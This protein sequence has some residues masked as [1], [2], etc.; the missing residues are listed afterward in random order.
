M[1]RLLV[2]GMSGTGK[3]SVLA[4]LAR[5]GVRVVDTDDEGW[6]DED[7]FDA[8]VL[9]SAP[10]GVL[11]HRLATR[12]TNGYGRSADERARV[13]ADLAEV[14][15]LLRRGAAAEVRTDRPLDE[16]VAAVLAVV[17]RVC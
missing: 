1:P 13:L 9:L 6:T 4:E 17:A 10:V 15:P 2:T 11:L 16:V 12:T 7:R 8:V 5:R 3:S 14:E